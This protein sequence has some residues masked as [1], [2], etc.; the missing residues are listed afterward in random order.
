MAETQKR[1]TAVKVSVETLQKGRFVKEEGWAPS[2]IDIN[3]S[4]IHRINLMAVVVAAANESEIKNFVVD[5]GTGS[6]T[7]RSF[8]YSWPVQVGELV[9]IIG[10]PREYNNERYL[11]P[12]IVKKIKNRK[13]IEV[14]KLELFSPPEKNDAPAEELEGNNRLDVIFDIIKK[15]DVG[16]G[17]A[18]ENIIEKTGLPDVEQI[19]AD[20]IKEGEIFEIR[21]GV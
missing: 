10:R 12:E 7:V 21:P 6:I 18:I 11:V 3:G 2:Y 14:R 9:A 1:H 19:V 5:D 8:E 16:Q 15:L 17:V 20:L 4:H 13:W